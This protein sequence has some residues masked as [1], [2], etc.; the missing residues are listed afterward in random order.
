MARCFTS[1]DALISCT[2]HIMTLSP[3]LDGEPIALI[4]LAGV[5]GL[6]MAY[7][8]RVVRVG[9]IAAAR[10]DTVRGTVLLGRYPIEA[11]HW[12]AR[13]VGRALSRV[14]VSPD[15]L[16]FLS[17]ALTLLTVPFAAAGYFEAAGAILILGSSLDALDGIVARELGMT[18]DAGEVLDSVMDRYS[19]TFALAGLGFFYRDSVAGLAIV[20][21]ALLGS[22]MVSYVRAKT[23]KFRVALPSTLMRR[24]ERIAYLSGALLL[25]P[26]LSAWVLPEYP[27]APVTL[28]ILA[29]VAIVANV[30][31]LQLL[32][33]A[34]HELRRRG[35]PPS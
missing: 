19:D 35:T 20:L 11:F 1:R 22:M 27:N 26:S 15:L 31:A 18:S 23:E 4:I 21:L 25:G 12:A 13:G 33:H 6:L 14:G 34:R 3:L 16:T 32:V 2:N 30:A 10:L 8:V 29:L 5:A 9:R 28:A 7:A 24:P 17:P